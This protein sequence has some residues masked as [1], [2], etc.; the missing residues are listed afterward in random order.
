MIKTLLKPTITS[1]LFFCLLLSSYSQNCPNADFSMG[2]FSNWV[3]RTGTY[4]TPATFNMTTPG[5]VTPAYHSI[6]SAPGI[7][8]NTCGGL[9]MIPPGYTNSARLNSQGNTGG[10]ASQLSYSMVVDAT[11]SLFIYNYAVVLNDGGHSAAQQ[12]K[13]EIMVLDPMNNIIACTYYEVA[14]GTGVPGFQ[15][16]GGVRWKDWEKVGVDLTPYMGQAITIQARVAGCVAEQGAHYGYAY[17]VGECQPLEILVEYCQGDTVATLTAPDGFSSY[18]WSTGETTQSIVI[19]NPIPG[20][21][22]ISCT[23][24]SVT[25]CQA[26]LNAI[27]TPVVVNAGFTFTDNCGLVQFTDTSNCTGTAN[28]IS[29]WAWDFDDA[30]STSNI[31]NPN[32]QY[33]NAG[34][35]DVTLIAT[36][37]AGCSDTVVVPVPVTGLPTAQFST[38]SG[39]GLTNTF[40]DNGSVGGSSAITSFNWDYGDGNT[41][42]GT[43]TNHTYAASGTWNIQ[44]VVTNAD[45]CTDTLI[46]PF[47]N[48]SIPTADFNVVDV[49]Q[50]DMAN[51]IDNSVVLGGAVITDWDWT[52]EPAVFINNTQNPSYQYGAPGLYNVQ[53]IVETDQN[54]FDTIVKPV[55]IWDIPVAQYS[56]ND[57]CL[58]DGSVFNNT[59]NVGGG[60]VITTYTWDFGDPAFPD[61][62]LQNPVIAYTTDGAYNTQLIVT[63]DHGCSDTT[64]KS[65]NVWPMP[66]IDFI[67][68]TLA[69]C[70]PFTADFTNTTTINSGT[71]DYTWDLETTTSTNVDESIMYPNL[72]DQYTITLTAISDHGCDT[73]ITRPDYITVY[74]K[75][76]AD[77][78]VNE[79]CLGDG[80]IFTDASTVSSGTITIYDWNFDDPAVPNSALQNPVIPYPQDGSYNVQ[81]I[82]T[83][84]YGCKDT[85][86][87]NAI[88]NPMPEIDFTAGPLVGCYP[89]TVTFDNLTTINSGS[90][91][92]TWD[93]DDGNGPGPGF[94]PSI[95]YPNLENSYTITLYA[96]SDKGCDTSITRPNYIT[97]HPKP[98]ASFTYTPTDLNVIDNVIHTTNLSVLGD[99]YFWDFGTGDGS[100]NFEDYYQY[101]GDTGTYVI[102]LVT[103]TNF[104]CVDTADAIVHIKPVFTIYIP[105]SFTPNDDGLND[106]FMV[107]GYNLTGVTMRIFDRWGEELLVMSGTDPV[108]KG[109]DGTYK[110]Q[111]A[112]QDVYVYRIE[113]TDI[114]GDY[115]EFIGQINLLR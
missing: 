80:S 87:K 113:V 63:T 21:T 37:T 85:V 1:I 10:A 47:T 16:C 83:T 4:N 14:A 91:T 7:D 108:T 8:P 57:V 15:T 34:T 38:P 44:L 35:Y 99:N 110:Q 89:F 22:N 73:S 9:Q 26:I 107:Y 94:E 115:H 31:Q 30:G 6:V 43:P 36:S 111:V 41:G 104:G 12:P 45:G 46:Q 67:V 97:V 49:C 75:P 32:H 51:F 79:P 88:V 2:N 98:T 93:L 56:V 13:F 58:G 61:N 102:T 40:A 74:P 52:V 76:T 77:F 82:I 101:T 71:V 96:V 5:I 72:Y 114:F 23:I 70:Y 50:Y 17:I 29:G 62:G 54:C 109:W 106:F 68:D 25:G 60:S 11:N 105:N 90:V 3:G 19:T 20:S 112:K 28:T 48:R 27:V 86:L 69:G 65:F 59:S 81:L 66:Q 42:V 18:A 78:T 92:Y 100:T 64:T 53:L 55:N 24:T 95:M 39:C 33:N 103:T 84:N